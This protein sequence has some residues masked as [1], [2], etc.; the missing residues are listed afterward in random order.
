M[1]EGKFEGLVSAFAK[2]FPRVPVA[3]AGHSCF[4]GKR[5]WE[6]CRDY[7]D[8]IAMWA[9]NE[10]PEQ[11]FRT[12]QDLFDEDVHQLRGVVILQGQ[13][14]HTEIVHMCL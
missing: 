11:A 3:F 2:H 5:L 14:S 7:D 1:E 13:L 9:R 6:V 4:G 12:H 8:V 10:S